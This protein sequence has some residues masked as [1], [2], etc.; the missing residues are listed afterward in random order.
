MATVLMNSLPVSIFNH[1]DRVVSVVKITAQE[2]ATL[3]SAGFT[4]AVGFASTAGLF[5]T[6]LGVEVHMNRINVS[7]TDADV[8]IVGQ[9][10]GPRLPE[11]SV[12]LPEGAVV[13]WYHVTTSPCD[14][15]QN[16]ADTTVVVSA[17]SIGMLPIEGC[18]IAMK[19]ATSSEVAAI[20]SST[21]VVS[22]VGHADTA[23]LF[24]TTLGVEVKMNR[25]NVS[26]TKGTRLVLG[27]Y[28]GPQLAPGQ[29]TLP[30]GASFEWW[31]IT[32]Q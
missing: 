6:L 8:V 18:S 3:L 23:G 25:L 19:A 2:A 24:T 5:S 1:A 21:S 14:V 28:K 27:Q 16:D 11:G 12:S 20:T 9:Y 32:L 7:V 30:E 13:T 15:V 31:I 29:T 10:T 17:F 22:G 4:S 26:L